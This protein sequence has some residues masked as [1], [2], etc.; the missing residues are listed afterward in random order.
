M[1][2]H[3]LYEEQKALNKKSS[4]SQSLKGGRG[5]FYGGNQIYTTG[6]KKQVTPFSGQGNKLNSDLQESTSYYE[7]YEM[8]KMLVKCMKYMT[9]FYN[10][11]YTTIMSCFFKR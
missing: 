7:M 11:I 9:L 6:F 4:D 1:N 2:I 5:E 8:Y 3:E 10:Y